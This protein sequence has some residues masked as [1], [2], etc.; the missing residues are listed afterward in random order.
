MHHRKDA[1]TLDYSDEPGDMDP[2]GHA[3][4]DRIA[5]YIAH[6]ERWPVLPDIRPGMLRDQLP[7][8]APATAS[9]WTASSRTSTA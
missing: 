4:M 6:P 1:M 2:E 8:E 5:D 3:V 7:A 9:P